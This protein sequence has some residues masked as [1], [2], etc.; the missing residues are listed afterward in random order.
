MEAVYQRLKENNFGRLFQ[1]SYNQGE[2][3]ISWKLTVKKYGFDWVY[4]Y[5]ADPSVEKSAKFINLLTIILLQVQQKM[6]IRN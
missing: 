5:A 6:N 1:D 2:F 3:R 4:W